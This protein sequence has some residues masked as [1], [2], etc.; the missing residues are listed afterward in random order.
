MVQLDK[1]QIQFIDNY[2]D[3]SDVVYADI[4]MEMVDHVASGIEARIDK[5]DTRDFYY[6]FKSA[7]SAGHYY[8]L[9]FFLLFKLHH[10]K[11]LTSI[12]L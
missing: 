2:L 4:R 8:S 9:L 12:T 6:I 1:E 5:G 11:D 7:F 3:N 10:L